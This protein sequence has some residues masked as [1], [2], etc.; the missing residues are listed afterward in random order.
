[1][2]ERSIINAIIEYRFDLGEP[3]W[4]WPQRDFERLSYSRWAV[5]EILV[6]IFNNHDWSPMRAAEEFKILM[7]ECMKRS[8]NYSETTDMYRIAYDAAN[9]LEDIIHAMMP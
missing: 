6:M 5:D 8:S 7:A 2:D 1:M 3:G 9:D 4:N